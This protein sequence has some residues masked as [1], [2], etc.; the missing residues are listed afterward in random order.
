MNK[1][2]LISIILPV[3]NSSAYLQ[4]ALDSV[5][6]QTYSN[7]ELITIND[8]S[9]DHSLNIL[10]SYAK[11]SSKIKVF[12]HTPNQGI[13]HT[14]NKAL[15]H[16]QGQYIARM[17]ADDIML[18]N[19]LQK[20]LKYLLKH[21]ETIVIGGQCQLID[22]QGKTI[23]KK[24]FPTS[25][26]QIYQLAFI[27]SPLQHPAIMINTTLLPKNFSWYHSDQVPAE[28]LD[29]YFRLFQYGKT[30]NLPDTIIKYRQNPQGLSLKNPLH[31]Y[32][33][34]YK[35]RQHARKN[36]QYQP[37][38]PTRALNKLISLAILVFPKKSIY[39][40]YSTISG[41]TSPQIKLLNLKS[42][43]QLAKQ[44]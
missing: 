21:P 4:Q 9:T 27:R 36:Y 26:Q 29:L 2:P 25:H 17:D 41:F 12:S 15:K 23:G 7:W 16:A 11:K 5:L 20:Q 24:T 44:G 8:A 37:T 3:Y 6:S 10:N 39:P 38:L 19:R 43:L 32:L 40:L 22:T 42:N 14:L 28:D 13:A 35:I 31:T 1:Q 33:T 30:A 34:A 18:P